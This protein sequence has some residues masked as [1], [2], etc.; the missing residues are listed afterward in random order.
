MRYS[1]G[2]WTSSL[3]MM[4]CG[5]CAF[6]ARLSAVDL[7]RASHGV[8]YNASIPALHHLGW[9]S[10]VSL[11]GTLNGTDIWD[12]RLVLEPR[13]GGDARA[14]ASGVYLVEQYKTR[15]DG[16]WAIAEIV[17]VLG[18]LR[19]AVSPAL[20]SSAR[21]RF[22]TDG[23]PGQLEPLTAFLAHVKLVTIPDDLDRTEKRTF[24]K[25]LVLTDREFFDHVVSATRAAAES[26]ARDEHAT[27]LHLLAHFELVFGS[28][29]DAQSAAVENLLRR[30][31]PDLGDERGIRQRLIEVLIETLSKGEALL[32]LPKI[33]AMFRNVGLNTERLHR[34]ARLAETLSARTHRRLSRVGYRSGRD[35]RNP[36]R[37]PENKPVLLIEGASGAGKTWQLGRLLETLGQSRKSPH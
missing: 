2:S 20:P 12:A 28:S 21:Y 11:S 18:N 26:P 25:N 22:V 14:D 17:S 33:D 35:V 23:R 9:M 29:G 3:R 31:A 8:G 19:Q 13:Q 32:D 24:S 16:T 37:W 1:H 15:E 27:V 5:S 30:Y 6:K 4:S 10:S 34:L 7:S 36:P